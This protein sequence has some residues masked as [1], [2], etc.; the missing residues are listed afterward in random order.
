MPASTSSKIT[1]DAPRVSTCRAFNASIIRES[2]PPDAMR[3]N[4][5]EGLHQDWPSGKTPPSPYLWESLCHSSSDSNMTLKTASGIASSFN[6]SFMASSSRS[7]QRP[8]SHRKAFEPW[9]GSSPLRAADIL[10]QLP[11]QGAHVEDFP[12][13]VR[14]SFLQ[15]QKPIQIRGMLPFEPPD[16]SHTLFNLFQPDGIAVGGLCGLPELHGHVFEAVDRVLEIL[17]HGESTE[18]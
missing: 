13:F 10:F 17:V 14:E 4:A 18:D 16:Q 11:C 6:S 2:S 7:Q 9:S 1:V 3:A 8:F 5:A 15:L 12:R